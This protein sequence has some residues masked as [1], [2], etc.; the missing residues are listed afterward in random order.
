ME[1]ISAGYA[2]N[3][4]IAIIK[5]N[6]NV[7]TMKDKQNHQN[8]NRGLN[9]VAVSPDNI[10]SPPYKILF[11]GA[12]DTCDNV[13]DAKEFER[14]LEKLPMGTIVVI[15]IRDEGSGTLTSA[16][17]TCATL[18]GSTEVFNVASRS[19]WACIGKIGE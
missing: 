6:G 8:Y 16:R 7:I 3:E 2:P 18:L 9:V 19:A 11:A 4:N 12:F 1:A 15:G 14:L 5:I 13:Q 17:S 10:S